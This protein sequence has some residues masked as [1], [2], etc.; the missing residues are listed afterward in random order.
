M[1]LIPKAELLSILQGDSPINA[2]ISEQLPNPQYG[3]FSYNNS[4]KALG[5]SDPFFSIEKPTEG[6][7]NLDN[8]YDWYLTKNPE[9]KPVNTEGLNIQVPEFK[10]LIAV[11]AKDLLILHMTKRYPQKHKNNT[12]PSQSSECSIQ[13]VELSGK[14]E[15]D[16]TKSIVVLEL[17]NEL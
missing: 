5:A 11:M 2:L 9:F 1:A 8:L 3:K 12:A 14:E 4:Q 6:H 13:S 10:F 16:D 17:I 15:T 7:F